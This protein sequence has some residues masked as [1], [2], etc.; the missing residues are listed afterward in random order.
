LKHDNSELSIQGFYDLTDIL[1]GYMSGS[2]ISRLLL[3]GVSSSIALT[4][5]MSF[6][7]AAGYAKGILFSTLPA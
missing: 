4:L 2:L 3:D 7:H 5:S 1:F 6:C